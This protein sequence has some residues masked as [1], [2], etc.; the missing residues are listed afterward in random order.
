MTEIQNKKYDLE[1][2][3]LEF[4]ISKNFCRYFGKVKVVL[5]LCFKF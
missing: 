4:G 5:D 1:E 3:T 2:R